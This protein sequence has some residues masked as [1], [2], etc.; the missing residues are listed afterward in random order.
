MHWL[1]EFVWG[2]QQPIW[3]NDIS[4]LTVFGEVAVLGGLY[5]RF[6]CSNPR[7][8]RLGR[9][10]VKGT[11]YRTCHPHATKVVHDALFQHHAEQHPEQHELLNQ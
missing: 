2:S 3:V 6:N 11:K 8:W 1:Y 5:K 9:H 7:C 10:P 4:N